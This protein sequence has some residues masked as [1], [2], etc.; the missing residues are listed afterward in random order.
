MTG[1]GSDGAKGMLLAKEKGASSTIAEAK[2][3]CVVYGMPGQRSS[4][5]AWITS[6]LWI[7]LR[8]KSWM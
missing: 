3:T 2:E 1:L 5:T 8:T 4:S 6:Y 7:G